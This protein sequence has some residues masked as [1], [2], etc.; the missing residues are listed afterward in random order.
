MKDAWCYIVSC[1]LMS[2]VVTDASTSADFLAKYRQNDTTAHNDVTKWEEE[3]AE[4][5]YSSSEVERIYE[6][7]TDLL[8]N[9]KTLAE[10]V[11]AMR[12]MMGNL[13]LQNHLIYRQLK[14]IRKNC[15]RKSGKQ[16]SEIQ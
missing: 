10:Q 3:M 14:R 9:V 1:L 11:T 8:D 6:L 16:I 15:Y 2:M 4:E 13:K 12:I 7:Q 5:D